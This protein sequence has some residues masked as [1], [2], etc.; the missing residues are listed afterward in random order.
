MFIKEVLQL[1]VEFTGAYSWMASPY[2]AYLLNNQFFFKYLLERFL[3]VLI[4]GLSSYT[5]PSA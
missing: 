2:P 3:D 1:T 4:I 5:K